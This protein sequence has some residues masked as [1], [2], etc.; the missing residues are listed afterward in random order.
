MASLR[1]RRQIRSLASC[2]VSR[3][4]QTLG[5]DAV[6]VSTVRVHDTLVLVRSPCPESL[7]PRGCLHVISVSTGAP[8]W[9]STTAF[10]ALF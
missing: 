5:H 1:W 3:F 4:V 10:G 8:L 2:K 7:G 9:H 6:I